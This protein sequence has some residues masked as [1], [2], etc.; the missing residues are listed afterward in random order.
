MADAPETLKML[1]EF[2][3][4]LK[5]KVKHMEKKSLLVQFP[6][7]PE[8]LPKEIYDRVFGEELP[9]PPKGSAGGESLKVVA[10][11][12]HGL[13]KKQL[14]FSDASPM[15]NMMQQMDQMMR[16]N[17][18][19]GMNPM[20]LMMAGM[21]QLMGADSGAA[22]AP[23][24]QI[25][26]T[27]RKQK[28]LAD[29]AEADQT[30]TEQKAL[31]DKA[32]DELRDTQ[33]EEKEP[34]EKTQRS[35]AGKKPPNKKSSFEMF[36]GDEPEAPASAPAKAKGKKT[37][38][39]YV[40]LF[41]SGVKNRERARAE[42]KKED[43][44]MKSED[45]DEAEASEPEEKQPKTKKRKSEPKSAETPPAKKPKEA[46]PKKKV[47]AAPKTVAKAAA[48]E[49]RAAA[50]KKEASAPE[51][52]AVPRKDLGPKPD[53]PDPWT[54]TFFWGTGKI[55]KN[56][57]SNSWRAFVEKSDKCDRKVKFGDDHVA[58]F[59]RALQIIEEGMAARCL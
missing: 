56:P 50:P 53:P 31:T 22:G 7:D 33:E 35:E 18:G 52:G 58:S 16:S 34:S 36:V 51:E 48:K 47:K 17:M 14:S 59:H 5:A 4:Q 21:Q 10:R 57:K 8:K 29:T 24:L 45:D 19:G 9:S 28:A 37:P 32:K 46:T 39:E 13:V 40:K 42:A 54:G 15:A 2:K 43:V 1:N 25:F 23:N 11:K 49:K 6:D 20:M 55:H 3:Q 38:E 12:S 41:K 27:K 30:P 44:E 26:G